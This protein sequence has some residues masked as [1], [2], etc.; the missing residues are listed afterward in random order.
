MCTRACRRC[1]ITL[2]TSQTDALKRPYILLGTGLG[3][4]VPK[5]L[6]LLQDYTGDN[7]NVET[8]LAVLAG[9]EVQILGGICRL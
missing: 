5:T 8:F 1:A 3:S 9:K 7:V 2:A 4:L 6:R